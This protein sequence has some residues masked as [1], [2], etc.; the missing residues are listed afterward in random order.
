MTLHIC[1]PFVRYFTHGC[2]GYSI[3]NFP[4]TAMCT[5]NSYQHEMYTFFVKHKVYEKCI[6]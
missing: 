6:G 3:T 1:R 4:N 2:Y 5:H